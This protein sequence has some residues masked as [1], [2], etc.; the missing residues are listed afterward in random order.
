MSFPR[1][2]VP[3][4]WFSHFYVFA[5]AYLSLLFPFV[6]RLYVSGIPPPKWII[7]Y[8]VKKSLILFERVLA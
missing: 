6:V 3:K 8:L 5:C 2:E 1:L 7:D 4:L